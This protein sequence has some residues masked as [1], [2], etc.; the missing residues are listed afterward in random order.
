MV[1]LQQAHQLDHFSCSRVNLTQSTPHPI[2]KALLVSHFETY[3]DLHTLSRSKYRPRYTPTSSFLGHYKGTCNDVPL[4][5]EKR[6][7]VSIAQ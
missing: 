3:S 1:H 6:N 2:K 5:K 7:Q 4:A